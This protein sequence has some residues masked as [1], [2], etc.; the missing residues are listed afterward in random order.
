M[1]VR[2]RLILSLTALA[3]LACSG[4]RATGP[5][6]AEAEMAAAEFERVGAELGASA[7]P[8]AALTYNSAAAALRGG[9]RVSLVEVTVGGV[10]ESW[11]AFGHEI[12]FELPPGF[13]AENLAPPPPLRAFL[14]WRPSSS[15][16][17][18]IHLLS[19]EESGPIGRIFPAT[20]DPATLDDGTPMAR[21]F[22]MY[23]E[24]REV[25]WQAVSGEQTSRLLSTGAACPVPAARAPMLTVPPSCVEA[26]F[27]FGF[28]NVEA[29]PFAFRFVS[30]AAPMP[31][32]GTRTLSMAPQPV[33]GVKLKVTL[34]ALTLP[35]IASRALP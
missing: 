13:A 4:D 8:S 24:N 32:S 3:A 2:S 23:A 31:A 12:Q 26:A 21:S 34:V 20:L 1:H 9:A 22:L 17:R 35:P 15:G 6:Q 11:N 27:T 28:S 29:H 19:A 18:V 30:G 16:L 33:A 7:G 14:A 10:T 25:L 5:S